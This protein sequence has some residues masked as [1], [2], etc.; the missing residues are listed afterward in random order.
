MRNRISVFLIIVFVLSLC[1]PFTAFSQDNEV[2]VMDQMRVT[3]TYDMPSGGDLYVK[4]ING[5]VRVTSWNSN[6]IEIDITRRGRRDDIEIIIDR[7]GKSISVEVDYPDRRRG[8]MGRNQN[9]S[10]NFD[11]K[12]PRIT[13]IEAKSTNGSVDV[14][15]IDAGVEAG[16]TNGS[17]E[18]REIKGNAL[19][20]STNGAVEMLGIGGEAEARST[21][22]RIKVENSGNVDAHTTNG[23]IFIR[24]VNADRIDA[25]STNGG[26]EVEIDNLNPGG[27][28]EFRTT[29][30]GVDLMIPGN[31]KADFTVRVRPRDLDSDFDIFDDDLDRYTRR[32]RSR[33][34]RRYYDDHDRNSPRTFR[35][36]LNGGGARINISTSHGDVDVRKR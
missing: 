11:I 12:V 16:T 35:G 10:V 25:G 13:E 20:H 31:S 21:N 32:D 9:G 36:K 3:K 34:S 1:L 14:T 19:G 33:S 2:I 6:K 17:V 7:R 29:N 26:I 23:S 24:N 28:Y 15:N 22:G 4:N 18:M 5:D 27:R 30:G 8:W